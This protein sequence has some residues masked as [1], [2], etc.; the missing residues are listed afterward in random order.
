MPTAP[1]VR[2]YWLAICS[3]RTPA[4]SDCGVLRMCAMSSPTAWS[5]EVPFTRAALWAATCTAGAAVAT[6][7]AAVAAAVLPLALLPPV[8]PA[9][10]A[11][12]AAATR[13]LRVGGPASAASA[14]DR[15]RRA[16][17]HAALKTAMRAATGAAC[18]SATG[19]NSCSAASSEVLFECSAC[20]EA[21][22]ADN[23]PP[24]SAGSARDTVCLSVLPHATR[25]AA[26]RLDKSWA[27]FTRSRQAAKLSVAAVA[28]SAC[29]SIGPLGSGACGA[30]L[31]RKPRWAHGRP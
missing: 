5:S 10:P 26:E 17:S 24:A 4:C 2:R 29:A 19:C 23:P 16:A 25:N 15:M 3:G 12:A 11:A 20:V 9:S 30:A 13:S 22:A 18:A 8:P 27:D 31:V 7:V 1:H 6:I 14:R 21:A 28:A